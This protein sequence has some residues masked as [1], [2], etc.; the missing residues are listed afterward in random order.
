[1]LSLNTKFGSETWQRTPLSLRNDTGWHGN[2]TYLA[3]GA[4][5]FF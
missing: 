5:A 4:G 1:M 2:Y 3:Y